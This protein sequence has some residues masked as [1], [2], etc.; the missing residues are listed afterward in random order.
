M[1]VWLLLCDINIM[2][3][4]L[5]TPA[6]VYLWAE[7]QEPHLFVRRPH[8]GDLGCFVAKG[9]WALL[10]FGAHVIDQDKFDVESKWRSGLDQA[11]AKFLTHGPQWALNFDRGPGQ[12]EIDG[13]LVWTKT[14]GM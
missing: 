7:K 2:W 12:E 14:N 10:P 8:V 1:T 11:W 6:S 9:Q 13:V 5:F 3:H 4:K